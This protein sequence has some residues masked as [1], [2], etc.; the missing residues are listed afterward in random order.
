M[1][2]RFFHA[3]LCVVLGL[4]HAT[5]GA[6]QTDAVRLIFSGDIMLDDGP[7]KV[8]ASG[9]DPLVNF[10][11]LLAQSD[12]AIGNLEC[13]VATTGTALANKI[14]TFRAKPETLQVLK[15]RFQGVSVANNH[16]GDYGKTAF[17]E[18]LQ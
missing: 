9:R 18:T 12:Y 15:G 7:G 14:F 17:L 6:A 2:S 1:N 13:P 8:I 4:L 3:L 10:A 16:S 5:T 11:A